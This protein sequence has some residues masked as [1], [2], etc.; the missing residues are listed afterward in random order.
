MTNAPISKIGTLFSPLSYPGS[1]MQSCSPFRDPRS[2]PARLLRRDRHGVRVPLVYR[3]EWRDGFGARGWKLLAAVGD[4]A[5]I[6]ST[7]ETGDRIPTSVLV[8]D[9]LDHWLSGFAVSGHR[10]EAMASRQLSSRTG[11]SVQAD[12]RQMV[13]E[14]LLYGQVNGESL[15]SFLP[16]DLVQALPPEGARDPSGAMRSLMQVLGRDVLRTRLV[17]RLCELGR[18]GERHARRSW[19]ALDL[20]Y[21]NR[22]AIGLALQRVLERADTDVECAAL[23]ELRACFL[24]GNAECALETDC[25]AVGRVRRRYAARVG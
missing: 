16:A 15:V 19:R 22:E 20:T 9:V 10:A 11:S 1:A 25:G 8:H 21:A 14:D 17:E 23:T 6:A 12:F 2:Y 3:R 24:V 5:I 18:R 7:R 13:D 4:P